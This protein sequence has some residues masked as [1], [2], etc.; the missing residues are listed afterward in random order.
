MSDSIGLIAIF[1]LGITSVWFQM[2][3]ARMANEMS[4]QV[5]TGIVDGTAVPTTQRWQMLYN[6]WVPYQTTGF[7]SA[8][9]IGVGELLL[10][11]LVGNENIKLLAYMGVIVAFV[12]SLF[13]LLT[14]SLIL[15]NMRS[16]LREAEAS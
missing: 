16:V 4:L 11:S 2:Y 3:I 9:F 15:T 8:I 1:F 14:G 12:G 13:W 7:V 6:M 10:A 5:C